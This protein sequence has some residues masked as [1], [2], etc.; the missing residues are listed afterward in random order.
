MEV[1]VFD[2]D[3]LA[4]VM[5]AGKGFEERINVLLLARRWPG[6]VEVEYRLGECELARGRPDDALT[7]WSRVPPG[8]PRGL[9]ATLAR[10]RLALK[11]GRFI[12]AERA[13]TGALAVNPAGPRA[14]GVR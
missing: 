5:A 9:D 6:D 12:E 3:D 7:S 10:G 13:L 4:Q 2:A 14:V 8:S 1:Y 11:R